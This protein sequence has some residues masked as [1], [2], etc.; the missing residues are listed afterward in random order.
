MIVEKLSPAQPIH[1]SNKVGAISEVS[2]D[3]CTAGSLRDR[4][5]TRHAPATIGSIRRMRR[6]DV[7]FAHHSPQSRKYWVGKNEIVRYRIPTAA[8][9]SKEALHDISIHRNPPVRNDPTLGHFHSRPA[10]GRDMRFLISFTAR[11]I[12]RD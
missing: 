9:Q 12:C 7:A 11:S 1:G 6:N 2:A 10:T 8:D 4:Q 5:P 3:D